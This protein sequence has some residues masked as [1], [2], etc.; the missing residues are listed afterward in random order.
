MR[1]QEHKA[2]I[3]VAQAEKI[4][5]RQAKIDHTAT[6]HAQ[7][8][9]QAIAAGIQQRVHERLA[10]I[11]TRC[12]QAV[13]D[14]THEFKI[15]FEQKRGKTEARLEFYENGKPV[16]YGSQS[17]GIID[18]A[19]FALR[20]AS[21]MLKHPASRPL[22]ILDE[23]FRFLHGAVHRER[24][25]NLLDLLAEEFEMQ[26]ILVTGVDEL[27]TGKIVELV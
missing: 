22:L 2:A 7:E 10:G 16:R 8:V 6:L 18:T 4:A 15:L 9:A 19:A 12:I 27:R 21:L 23:P 17:G 25:R 3:A 1:Q 14:E 13:F 5:L 11:V 20:L 24:M 26:I